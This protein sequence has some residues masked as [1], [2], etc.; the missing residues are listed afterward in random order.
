MQDFPHHYKTTAVARH[1]SN[2]DMTSPGLPELKLAA[3]AEFGGPGDHWSPE[4][5]MAAAVAS[6]FKLSFK[7]IARAAKF[8]WVSIR[9]DVVAVLDRVDK[10]TQFTEFHQTVVLEVPRGSDEAKAIRLLEKAE[11]SCLVTNSLTGVTRLDAT[12]RVS[13]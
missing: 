7:A 4:T 6:C 10:V 5:L 3:P 2:V 1:D 8:E 9:C 13:D 12:V 11:R